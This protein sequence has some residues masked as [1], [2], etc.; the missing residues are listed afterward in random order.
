MQVLLAH[1]SL[2]ASVP[3]NMVM[4]GID[5]R[6]RQKSLRDIL[7][8]WISFRTE[9]L[10]RRISHRL[11][12]VRDRIHILE[13][14]RLVLLNVDRVIAVIRGADEP[15]A[16]LMVAFALTERQA[17][18][19][20]EM[21]LR[22]LAKL[23]A[24]KI[25]QEL[26]ELGAE[27]TELA[28]LLGDAKALRRR[29][30]REIEADA[31][32]FGD[33]RRT[34]IEASERVALAASVVDEPITV[35]FSRKAWVRSRS[36]HGHDPSTFGFKEGD[37]L[38][39]AI[40]CRSVDQAV[41]LAS[42]G[43]VFTLPVAQLPG[44]RGDGV[45]VASLIELEAGARILHI[46]AGAGTQEYL[47]SGS[48]GYGFRAM[49]GDLTSRMRAGKQFL[50]LEAGE[51]PLTPAPIR[52]TAATVVTLSAKGRVLAFP[53]A[54]VKAL[55]AGG[56]GVILMGLDRGERLL[57]C[58]AADAGGALVHGEWRGKAVQHLLRG[59]ALAELV[60]ARAR[61]GKLLPVRIK[62]EFLELPPPAPTD[63]GQS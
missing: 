50:N 42:N 58:V 10:R 15:K 60:G 46:I 54:E 62:P 34:P 53:L 26:A 16:E 33:A 35:L 57:S 30:V 49:L 21:R 18:D 55:A 5:G 20:L 23:E 12:R 41:F 63:K 43:R 31:K 47:F 17:D 22:Q 3:I 51:E 6:P 2:E 56:R 24:I 25:E 59:A 9:T 39:A 61:K 28:N 13:G 11:G 36:G 52:P 1:T 4:I 37:T 8:E 7:G 38:A 29:L 27:E 32:Q 48:G 44:G 40:E 14:R 45:P 19:I